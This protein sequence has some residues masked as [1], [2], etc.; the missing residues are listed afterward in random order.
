[1]S[2]FN[3][4]NETTVENNDNG[5]CANICWYCGENLSKIP[6]KMP[7]SEEKDMKYFGSFCSFNHTKLFIME[8]AS[9]KTQKQQIQKKL[10]QIKQDYNESN[11]C[12]YCDSKFATNSEIFKSHGVKFCSVVCYYAWERSEVRNLRNSLIN[13]YIKKLIS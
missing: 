5:P 7:S 6:I 2:N 13:N 8:T 11:S 9:T 4:D 1:M 3:V 10:K 12:A